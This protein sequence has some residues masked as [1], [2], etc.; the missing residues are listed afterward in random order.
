[1]TPR[2]QPRNE[3]S[4]RVFLGPREPGEKEGPSWER[5]AAHAQIWSAY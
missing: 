2:S 1:L 3:H 5:T 4:G